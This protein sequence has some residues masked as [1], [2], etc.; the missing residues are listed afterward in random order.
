MNQLFVFL[1]SFL[2]PSTTLFFFLLISAFF[3]NKF[4]YFLF[5]YFWLHWVLVAVHKLSLVEESGG[6]SSLQCLG[7]SL[8]WLLFLRSTGSRRTGFHSCGTWA[9]QLWFTGSRAQAQQLWHMGLVAPQH[10]GSSRSRDRTR[11]P[12]IGRQIFN[13]CA[14]REVLLPLFL[15]FSFFY[16]LFFF[17]V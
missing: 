11:V 3:F 8:R 10:V 9:Q 14:I 17:N 13:R 6:Y 2:Q 12:C 5:I 15:L 16:F 1:L 4:I 7:F